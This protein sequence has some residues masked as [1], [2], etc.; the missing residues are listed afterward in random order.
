[1]LF[2]EDYH[3][4]T[5]NRPYKISYKT[6]F[7]DRLKEVTFHGRL[8]YPLYVQVT[9]NRQ[10]IFFKSYYFE[11]YSKPKYLLIVSGVG[12]K[13]PDIN[14]IIKKE[15]HIIGHLTESKKE[16]FSLEL[17]K[18]E[19]AYYS[20]DIC[21]LL[22]AEFTQYLFVFFQDKGMP[23]LAR[24]IRQGIDF[25]APYEV[26]KDMKRILTKTFYD[27]LVTNSFY[28][29][30]P[31]FALYGFMQQLHDPHQPSITK[32]LTVLEWDREE[33]Q[34]LFSKYIKTHHKNIDA[35]EVIKEVNERLSLYRKEISKE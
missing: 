30:T 1:V 15:N 2:A 34:A 18:Q 25:L 23:S 33:T 4:I 17:F 5:M 29:G 6:Y 10:T 13:A 16:D 12:T 8:T 14:A 32:I 20:K 11:L 35:V 31:Y 24:T 28:Y 21:D 27:E 22:E 7:N 26:V 19:Y 3:S 9:F